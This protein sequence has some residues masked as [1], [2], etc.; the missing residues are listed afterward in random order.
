MIT[1]K[2]P[3]KDEPGYLKR[4]RRLTEFQARLEGLRP[5]EFL[6]ATVDFLADYVEKPAKREKAIEALWDMSQDQYEEVLSK[7][8]ESQMSPNSPAPSGNGAA[9]KRKRRRSKRS[10]S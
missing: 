5:L 2:I 4:Q 3:G 9:A 8:T 7:I 1:F 6:D 10:S